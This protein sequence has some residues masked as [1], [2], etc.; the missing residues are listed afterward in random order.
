MRFQI[1]LD[2]DSVCITQA[3]NDKKSRITI[4]NLDKQALQQLATSIIHAEL[5]EDFLQ[6]LQKNTGSSDKPA[7]KKA[8]DSTRYLY[9]L[10]IGFANAL[11]EDEMDE[12]K[13]ILSGFSDGFT[14][15]NGEGYFMEKQEKTLV[16]Q[17]ATQDPEIPYLCADRL[18]KRFKQNSIGLV[19]VNE[20]ERIR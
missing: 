1:S 16:I 13:T 8:P 20:Y 18:K 6:L 19:K 15:M 12:L 9:T 2:S 4:T 11:D 14:I 3:P 5:E 10:F 7:E 17:L